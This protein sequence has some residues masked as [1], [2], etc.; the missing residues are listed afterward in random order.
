MRRTTALLVLNALLLLAGQ[1]TLRAAEPAAKPNVVFILCDDLGY[2]DVACN[3]PECKIPT[4][5]VDRL[6]GEGMR[7]TDAHTT[8]SVCTPTRYSVLTG[9]YNWR[10]RLQ[11]G[12]LGGL[13]P[14]LIEPGRLTVAVRL[15]AAKAT[16]QP[17]LRL[18]LEGKLGGRPFV[19]EVL[20]RVGTEWSRPL[21][22]QYS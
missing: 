18:A 11:S 13:S 21:V 7:F 15:R 14:P 12:V 4:P 16:P 6:A 5:H 8:S 10:S 3:N 17:P 1:H 22:L 19:R 2:G 20:L 9:R